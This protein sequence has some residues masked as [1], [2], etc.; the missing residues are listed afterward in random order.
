M[1]NMAENLESALSS[2]PMLPPI[3]TP[4]FFDFT[5]E[6][7]YVDTEI[8]DILLY[9]SSPGSHIILGEE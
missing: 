1:T 4:T 5:I 7:N 3:W 8:L 2:S 6:L 9:G